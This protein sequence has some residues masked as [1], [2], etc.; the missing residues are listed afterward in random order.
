MSTLRLCGGTNGDL[1]QEDLHH[2]QCLPE[3]LWPVLLSPRQATADPCLH[4]RSSSTHRQVWLSL[5]WQPL[6]LSLGPGAHKV[7]F[8]PS[9]SLVEMRFDIK[10]DCAS[11]I[12]LF[13]LPI[14]PWT[15]GIFFF[16]GF[17]HPPFNGC[18]AANCGFDVLTEEDELMPFCSTILLVYDL[19]IN[20]IQK[21]FYSH[22][23]HNV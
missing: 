18:S 6:L 1:L 22:I 11:P 10:H 5:L 23:Q 9:K 8:V 17:Q 7:L 19:N 21:Y 14:C 12:V 13:Q 3:L 16:G 2:T 20:F 15:W 4:R